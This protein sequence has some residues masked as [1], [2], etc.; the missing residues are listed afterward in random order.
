MVGNTMAAADRLIAETDLSVR[1]LEVFSISRLDRLDQSTRRR[2]LP[3]DVPALSV[4][5]APPSVLG[6]RLG[7]RSA[8]I[9]LSD[10]GGY[11]GPV[12][13]LYRSCGLG[14]DD[15]VLSAREIAGVEGPSRR[16]RGSRVVS[17]PR[18]K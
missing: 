10:Y 13:A 6:C 1:V 5:N 7:S 17:Q 18:C 16:L 11:G 14:V 8:S 4:H 2:L 3:E 9:G 15:I 12:D